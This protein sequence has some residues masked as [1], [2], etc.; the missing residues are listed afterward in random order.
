MKRF[1][2]GLFAAALL[3]CVPVGATPAIGKKE[4]KDCTTCHVAK[5]KKDLNATGQFYKEKKTLEGLE[6][7]LVQ[8][9][10]ESLVS[11]GPQPA[12]PSRPDEGYGRA[13]GDAAWPAA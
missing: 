10:R 3:A 12:A 13:T 9:W 11:N 8:L 6:R 7:Y 4:G 5:G 1:V 2:M